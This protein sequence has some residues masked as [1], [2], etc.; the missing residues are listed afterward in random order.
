[1]RSHA[2]TDAKPNR[3]RRN[4]PIATLLAL[5]ALGTLAQALAPAGAAATINQGG[6]PDW[7][8]ATG[9]TWSTHAGGCVISDGSGGWLV[10]EPVTVRDT[11]CIF[12]NLPNQIGDGSGAGSGDSRPGSK[13]GKGGVVRPETKGQKKPQP[14]KGSKK[15]DPEL[16]PA[17]EDDLEPAREDD[18]EPA[19]VKKKGTPREC[20]ALQE[21]IRELGGLPPQCKAGSPQGWIDQSD[22][23]PCSVAGINQ[24]LS[25]WGDAVDFWRK[26]INA[27]EK[28]GSQA[29]QGMIDKMRRKVREL[30]NKRWALRTAKEDLFDMQCLGSGKSG[31]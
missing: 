9:G 15:E 5:L 31:Y 2:A 10:T 1:M 6:T 24:T 27:E 8:K 7:C 26:E 11:P 20:A 22:T 30:E 17:R 12:C 23:R 29:N 16:E 19:R 18:L 28:A 4:T 21:K 14:K 25:R 3:R 13:G